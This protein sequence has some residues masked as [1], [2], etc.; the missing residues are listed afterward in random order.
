MHWRTTRGHFNLIQTEKW[1]WHGWILTKILAQLKGIVKE[2]NLRPITKRITTPFSS[3][4]FKAS[5]EIYSEVEEQSY[6]MSEGDPGLR[7][8]IRIRKPKLGSPTLINFS[9]I[10]KNISRVIW[11]LPSTYSPKAV[12]FQS[13]LFSIT[14]QCVV[15]N[16]SLLS[17]EWMGSWFM[18]SNYN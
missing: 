4:F 5:P 9:Y 8:A 11:Q 16:W 3:S 7:S 2:Q 12:Q 14:S 13:Q 6:P 15:I 17:Y 10:T 18:F 1:E